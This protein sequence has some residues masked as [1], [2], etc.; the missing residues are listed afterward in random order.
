MAAGLYGHDPTF[1]ATMDEVLALFGGDLR[2]PWLAGE[3]VDDTARSQPLLFAVDVALG[4][5]VLSWG[6]R[7]LALIG[8]SVGEMAAATLAGVFDLADAVALTEDRVHHLAGAPEGGMLAVAASPEQVGPYLRD[9]VVVGAEN[10]PSQVLLAGS[11][12]PL[13]LV[14]QSLR[15]SGFVC[16]RA[17]ADRPFHSPAVGVAC[18]RSLPAFRAVTLH[19][20]GLPLYSAYLADLLP[21]AGTPEFWCMQPAAVVRFGPTLDLLLSRQDVLLV[22]AG[23]GQGLSTL[24]R[25]H[26]AVASKASAVVAV[27]P[28]KFRGPDADRAAALAAMN[29]I[30]EG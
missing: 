1:T 6:V 2:T 5:M 9:D 16:M 10:A 30:R 26:R 29:K 22:E 25:R 21:D 14:E 19:E 17:K 13:A 7:P 27:L 8:H 3:P 23:P 4:T 24:A 18:E 20:P 15:A 12:E 28:D 11:R